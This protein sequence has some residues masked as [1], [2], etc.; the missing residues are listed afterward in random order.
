MKVLCI[1]DNELNEL[2]EGWTDE[3]AEKLKG[4][5]LIL[6]AGD[7]DPE[8][9]EFI[10]TMLNVPLLYVRGN[11][12]S[13]YDEEPPEGCVDIDD[14]VVEITIGEDGSADICENVIQGIQGTKAGIAEK[15]GLRDSSRLIRIA[16]LG[17]SITLN[18]DATEAYQPEDEYTEGEMK[19]RVRKV[20]WILRN[21]AM[22]DRILSGSRSGQSQVRPPLDILLT[23]SP[24]EGHGDLP[25]PAHTGFRCFNEILMDMKPQYHIY[26]HVHM[27]YGRITRESTH[28][29][30]TCSINVCGMYILDI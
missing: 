9:L 27:E 14:K 15:A 1:S 8:Y 7:L 5:S 3:E 17:G 10:E 21:Y 25:D 12:D 13:R 30:G 23:H 26:G 4:I 22:A 18:D 20:S 29:S 19:A 6:S 11:H 24:A 28:E 2:Y 16:G